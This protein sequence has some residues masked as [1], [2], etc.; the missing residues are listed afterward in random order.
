MH[1][2]KL[3]ILLLS[4]CIL[5]VLS[6]ESSEELAEATDAILKKE[7]E[8]FQ[9]YKQKF[10]ENNVNVTVFFTHDFKSEDNNLL[11]R[12][13]IEIRPIVTKKESCKLPNQYEESQLKEIQAFAKK[14][15]LSLVGS[16]ESFN[17]DGTLHSKTILSE[18]VN[19]KFEDGNSH[20]SFRDDD[21]SDEDDDGDS[22]DEY[23]G[24]LKEFEL[25]ITISKTLYDESGAEIE[26]VKLSY[27]PKKVKIESV[28][29]MPVDMQMKVAEALK[30]SCAMKEEGKKRIMLLV[31]Y[32][33]IQFPEYTFQAA[34]GDGL[35]YVAHDIYIK[36]LFEE[37]VY[38]IWG[39]T[40]EQDEDDD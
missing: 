39:T 21:E 9:E 23:M 36:V 18:H 35:H 11:K 17:S 31:R 12:D 16:R 19:V 27:E 10:D 38:Q 8:R 22:I 40:V 26:T 25:P 34:I 33:G 13:T 20:V 14:L 15:N 24:M 7:I 29:G 5:S 6:G 3:L 2:Q 30:R 37:Q 28:D 1:L 32:L 4:S